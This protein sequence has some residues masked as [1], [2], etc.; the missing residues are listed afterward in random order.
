MAMKTSRTERKTVLL[1]EDCFTSFTS[2]LL[3][4][5]SSSL[6]R[7]PAK[8]AAFGCSGNFCICWVVLAPS[9]FED[10]CAGLFSLACEVSVLKKLKRS[11]R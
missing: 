6:S 7:S 4:S 9:G 1:L 3:K 5:L 8:G 2:F 11:S 10:L